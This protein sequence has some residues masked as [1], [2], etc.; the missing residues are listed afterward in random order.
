[1]SVVHDDDDIVV[2][3]KP[4][5]VAAHPSVGWTGPNVLAG[6]KA[7][8]QRI[9]KDIADAEAARAKADATLREYNTQ[10]AGAEAKMRDMLAKAASDAEK[11]ATGIRMQAQQEA[12]EAKERATRDIEAAKNQAL[13]EIYQQAADLSTA[14]DEKILRRNLNPDDQP[15]LVNQSLEQ[16]TSDGLAFLTRKASWLELARKRLRDSP[17]RVLCA[18]NARHLREDLGNCGIQLI[19]RSSTTDETVG[20]PLG[21]HLANDPKRSIVVVSAAQRHD[22]SKVPPNAAV[23]RPRAA[24]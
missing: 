23:Q 6:L 2:V 16:L 14:I 8:E 21:D 20:I 19:K 17:S 11:L 5:G 3:D 9:R 1:M 22:R 7:R 13:T 4:V 15:D 12:E 24:A 10:L 18:T